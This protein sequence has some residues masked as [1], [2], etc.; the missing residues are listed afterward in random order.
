MRTYPKLIDFLGDGRID[1][2]VNSG[3]RKLLELLT[4][5]Q[6]QLEENNESLSQPSSVLAG[7]N[8]VLTPKLNIV[9]Q[10]VGSRGDVQ[11]FIS[12]G[13][14]L[15]HCSHRVRI[16][17]HPVFQSSIED[18]GLEF[19]SIGGDPAELMAFMC[20]NPGLMPNY[21][22]VRKGKVQK[23]RNAMQEMLRGCWRSCFEA[24]NGLHA[25]ASAFPKEGK[26]RK[27]PSPF[28]AD[29]IIANPPAFAHIHCAE[30]LGIPLHLMFTFVLMIRTLISPKEFI[31]T[32]LTVCPGLPPNL[33]LIRWPMFNR[34]L[35][36]PP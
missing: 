14:A 32:I 27:D 13:L 34:P 12:L 36:A 31:L 6:N 26:L 8:D 23:L 33:L 22:T 9:I 7:S 19:F 5:V 1:I 30:K 3:A 29:A 17:T 25:T 18:L 11:P 4:P 35:R 10:I 28:V 16:A 24:G 21:D 20:R 15:K 2:R